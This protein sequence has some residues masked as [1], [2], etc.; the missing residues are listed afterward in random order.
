MYTLGRW[1]GGIQASFGGG[2]KEVGRGAAV[3]EV[4]RIRVGIMRWA[5]VWACMGV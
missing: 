2:D 1:W 4:R 5:H 3:Y